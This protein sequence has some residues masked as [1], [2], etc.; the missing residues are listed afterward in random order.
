MNNA[1]GAILAFVCVSVLA[2]GYYL[3]IPATY[4]R[5]VAN[6]TDATRN[7]TLNSTVTFTD[8]I[9]NAT[10]AWLPWVLA[11]IAIVA[12]MAWIVRGVRG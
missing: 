5:I 3:V 10:I 12:V 2:L 7:A 4:T 9:Q 1:V 11:G 6:V 8:T